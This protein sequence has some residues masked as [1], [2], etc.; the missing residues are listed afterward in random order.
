MAQQIEGI[1]V[2]GA[3]GKILCPHE[4]VRRDKIVLIL[5]QLLLRER[6]HDVHYFARRHESKDN[7]CH[8]VNPV[9]SALEEHAAKENLM[10]A[11]LVH[12]PAQGRSPATHESR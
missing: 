8:T 11:M 12:A 7:A 3:H 5:D 2:F 9:M 1:E 10:N 4:Q 6:I